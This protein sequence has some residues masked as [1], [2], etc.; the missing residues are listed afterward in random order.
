MSTLKNTKQKVNGNLE[1]YKHEVAE[2]LGVN[3]GPDATAEENGRVGG[4]MT[5]KLVERGNGKKSNS[6]SSK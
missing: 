2:E 1:T 5:K 4:E 6:K 3:L